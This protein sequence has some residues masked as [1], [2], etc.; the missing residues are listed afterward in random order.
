MQ[1]DEGTFV[2]ED[3][4]LL[5]L[6]GCGEK[7]AAMYRQRGKKRKHSR[8]SKGGGTSFRGAKESRLHQRRKKNEGGT[9]SLLRGR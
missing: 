4:H 6:G 2:D 9:H 3:R 8:K 1:K 7:E 5:V